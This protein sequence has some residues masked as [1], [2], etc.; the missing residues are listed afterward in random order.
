[1]TLDEAIK[2]AREKAK[3]QRE[4]SLFEKELYHTC[5]RS[6]EEH[7]QLAEWL[8]E[9]KEL[10]AR[11]ELKDKWINVEDRLPKDNIRVLV[12]CEWECEHIALRRHNKWVGEFEDYEDDEVL[13]WMP[14][15]EPYAQD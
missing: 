8:E 3:V 4:F 6:A 13:A 12:Y 2:H 7:E 10:R 5:I 9:L 15:P 14:L 1:M 11:V